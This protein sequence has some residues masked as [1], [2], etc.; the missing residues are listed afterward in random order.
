MT[1]FIVLSLCMILTVSIC[2]A[3][4]PVLDT[5]PTEIA[6]IKNR[7]ELTAHTPILITAHFDTVF[8]FA[9]YTQSPAEIQG[10]SFENPPGISTKEDIYIKNRKTSISYNAP[11]LDKGILRIRSNC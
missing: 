7:I 10:T 9:D 4:S 11:P 8:I 3:F 6:I 1:K 2:S 5:S